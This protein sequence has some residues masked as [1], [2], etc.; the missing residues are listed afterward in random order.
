V[1]R[2]SV[3]LAASDAGAARATLGGAL[4]AARQLS[5]SEGAVLIDASR[6]AFISAL[7]L[8]A[9]ISVAGS[10][11]LAAFVMTTMRRVTRPR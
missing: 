5:A 8:C 9:G 7:Q 2:I 4:A 10:L 1:D 3:A 11:L 6:G